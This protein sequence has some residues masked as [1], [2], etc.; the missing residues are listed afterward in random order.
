MKPLLLVIAGIVLGVSGMHLVPDFTG[1]PIILFN[2]NS[3]EYCREATVSVFTLYNKTG[4]IQTYCYYN[5]KHD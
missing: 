1:K 2:G 5:V 3:Q 4:D